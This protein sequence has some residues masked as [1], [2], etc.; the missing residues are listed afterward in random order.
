MGNLDQAQANENLYDINFEEK[1]AEP[2]DYYLELNEMQS[3]EYE[4]FM[5]TTMH[6]KQ[7]SVRSLNTIGGNKAHSQLL[8]WSKLLQKVCIQENPPNSPAENE[9]KLSKAYEAIL[10]LDERNWYEEMVLLYKV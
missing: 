7:K 3:K 10:K 6:G 8:E 9:N 5:A 2:E 4:K 1:G